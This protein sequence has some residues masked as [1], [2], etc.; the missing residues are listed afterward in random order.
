MCSFLLYP[1]QALLNCQRNVYVCLCNRHS[2]NVELITHELISLCRA[3][4]FA[5]A[6]ALTLTIRK[7]CENDS[8]NYWP[9][10]CG[11][12]ELKLAIDIHTNTMDVN[13]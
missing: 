2:N 11:M 4:A 13:Y 12:L 8:K 3:R 1:N 6:R 7:E 10:K 9:Y 5:S